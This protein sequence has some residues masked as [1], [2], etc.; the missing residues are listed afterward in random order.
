MTPCP[1]CAFND[2][3]WKDQEEWELWFAL[4]N[5]GPEGVNLAI[6]QF[7]RK[8][9]DMLARARKY[10]SERT[11]RTPSVESERAAREVAV[12]LAIQ[13]LAPIAGGFQSPDD[14]NKAVT[15]FAAGLGDYIQNGA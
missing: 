15:V 14:Y 6:A 11:C 12:G 13:A 1:A 5:S 4:A 3:P 2:S 10:R 7:N 9:A 8:L